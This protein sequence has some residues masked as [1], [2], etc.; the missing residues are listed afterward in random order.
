MWGFDCSLRLCMSETL[1]LHSSELCDWS[2]HINR[3][4]LSDLTPWLCWLTC[5]QS[6]HC[7]N[8]LV[9]VP[10]WVSSTALCWLTLHTLQTPPLSSASLTPA[11]ISLISCSCMLMGKV[12]WWYFNSLWHKVFYSWLI[13]RAVGGWRVVF[14]FHSY[15]SNVL[16]QLHFH[17]SAAEIVLLRNGA[18]GSSFPPSFTAGGNQL[19]GTVAGRY[20][21]ICEKPQH[22]G[23]GKVW[24]FSNRQ[25]SQQTQK[26]LKVSK[27]LISFF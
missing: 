11:D 17:F 10:P 4:R 14:N 24:S 21:T 1:L 2:Q 5:H 27:T 23:R 26:V 8:L 9:N 20:Q 7:E 3:G 18:A 25:F 13:N 16:L 19:W 22:N 12:L 15:H 6:S